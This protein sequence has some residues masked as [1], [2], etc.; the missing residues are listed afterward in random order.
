MRFFSGANCPYADAVALTCE[1][2]SITYRDLNERSNRIARYLRANGSVQTPGRIVHG[3]SVDLVVALVG[4]LKAGGAYLPLDPNYPPE[5]LLYMLQ[6]SAPLA[7][8]TSSE[9]LDRFSNM[10]VTSI[11]IDRLCDELVGMPAPISTRKKSACVRI[12]LHM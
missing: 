12:I 3:R 1:G 4:V 8:L 6:D 10:S 7:L 11:A 9:L 2:R 5:R